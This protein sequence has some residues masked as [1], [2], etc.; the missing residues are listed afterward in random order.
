MYL[1]YLHK[2][3]PSSL[4]NQTKQAGSIIL[5]SRQQQN[6]FMKHCVCVYQACPPACINQWTMANGQWPT[7]NTRILLCIML[8]QAFRES[9]IFVTSSSRH[10]TSHESAEH[11]EFTFRHGETVCCTVQ[12]TYN[13]NAHRN[14]FR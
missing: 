11:L 4:P 7:A 3:H 6:Y 9:I 8:P 5:A 14:V 10:Y 1:F 2:S 12:H 13:L